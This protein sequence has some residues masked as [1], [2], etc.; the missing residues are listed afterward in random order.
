M[1]NG[2]TI[3]TKGS[4]GNVF[5][6]LSYLTEIQKKLGHTPNEIKDYRN[7]LL[8]M[9]YEEVLET[10]EKDYGLFIKFV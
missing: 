5:V 6:V 9:K 4:E 8:E 2:I 3:N 10:I 1:F 7:S